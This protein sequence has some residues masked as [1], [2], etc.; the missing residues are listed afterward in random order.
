MI[1]KEDI[2][3]L[4]SFLNTNKRVATGMKMPKN[5]ETIVNELCSMYE[6]QNNQ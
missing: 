2:K 6:T 4:R 3:N 1:T 5:I